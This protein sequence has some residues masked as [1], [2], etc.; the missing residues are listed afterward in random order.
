MCGGKEVGIY[1]AAEELLK[2]GLAVRR[3]FL[4]TVSWLDLERQGA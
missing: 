3:I 1:T 2:E 4:V